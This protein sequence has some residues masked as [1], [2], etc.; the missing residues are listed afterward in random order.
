MISSLNTW[1][2]LLGLC[3]MATD[4]TAGTLP[5]RI[6]AKGAS[7]GIKDSR[8]ALIKD[9]SAWDKCWSQHAGMLKP[10]TAAPSVNFSKEMVIAATMGT[11]RTGG[12]GIE[13]SSVEKTA[14]KLKVFVKETSPPPGMMSIQILTSPYCFAAVPKTALEPEFIEI[15]SPARK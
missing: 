11:R 2:V 13:I 1:L 15:K 10:A 5:I 12:Y 3:L 6:L 14:H 7:S 8:R 4:G 9:A